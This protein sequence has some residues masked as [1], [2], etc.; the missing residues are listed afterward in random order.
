MNKKILKKIP[1]NK[2]FD[3]TDLINKCIKSK[4]KIGIYP[5]DIS[6]W[7]DVGNWEDYKKVEN[8]FL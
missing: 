2:Y 4:I 7:R 1:K 3:T 5:I 6:K 8:S